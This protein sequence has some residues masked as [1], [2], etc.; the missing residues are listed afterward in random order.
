MSKG[1]TTRVN[2]KEAIW[3]LITI[4][5]LLGVYL[6]PLR[7]HLTQVRVLQDDIASL[8]RLGP[9]VFVLVLALV[10]ALGVPRLLLFPVGG[11]AFGL[12]AGLLW[13]L[14]GSLAGAYAAFLYA[15]HAGRGVV[16]KKWPAALRM[17]ATLEGRGFLTVA[18]LRQLPA[19]GHLTNIFLGISP[20][21]HA[22][23]LAGTL[24]GA[25]PS[26]V[27]AIMVG[28]SALQ[29]GQNERLLY[30]GTALGVLAL[31]WIGGTI[32]V[33][34]AGLMPRATADETKSPD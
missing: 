14:A 25:L 11:L 34:R 31:V 10:T 2:R 1:S 13:C 8:G 6:S 33:S 5:G 18:L 16:A 12:W 29:A 30:L 23:F 22:A 24:L 15:R 7:E 17:S 26:A 3:L 20:V 32:F 4:A 19:P 9:L 27:P 21:G 28:S